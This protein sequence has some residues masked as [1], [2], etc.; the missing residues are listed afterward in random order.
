MAKSGLM[1]E[2]MGNL[3]G[4][5]MITQHLKTAFLCLYFIVTVDKLYLS[6]TFIFWSNACYCIFPM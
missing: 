6:V 4:T 1:N 2:Y 5:V 3:A